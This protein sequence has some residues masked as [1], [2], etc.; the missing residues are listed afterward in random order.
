MVARR[1]EVRWVR[2]Y[3]GWESPPAGMG[4]RLGGLGE[5]EDH[6]VKAYSASRERR[7]RIFGFLALTFGLVLLGLIIY[8]MLFG[9]R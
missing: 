8:T 9:Y 2:E 5:L 7:V 1:A 4:V 6:L 3:K